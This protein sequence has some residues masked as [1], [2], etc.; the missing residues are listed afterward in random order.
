MNRGRVLQVRTVM[1]PFAGEVQG[2]RIASDTTLELAAK[3]MTVANQSTAVVVD[4]AGRAI[5]TIDLHT[6]IAAMVTPSTHKT[7][8]MAAA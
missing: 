4:S 5:G 6:I 2:P 3:E 1:K 7:D 8:Q